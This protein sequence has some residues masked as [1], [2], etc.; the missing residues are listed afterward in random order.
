MASSW[1]RPPD[2][3]FTR[4]IFELVDT[5]NLQTGAEGVETLEQAAALRRLGHPH[6]Q[7]YLFG[8]AMPSAILG[9]MLSTLDVVVVEQPG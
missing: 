8:R 6:A 2:W 1:S 3:P 4:A 7:G 5:L 9:Q